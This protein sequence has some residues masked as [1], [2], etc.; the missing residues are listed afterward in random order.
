MTLSL[1]WMFYTAKKEKSFFV[2]NCF[3]SGSF[4]LC[5]HA[6]HSLGYIAG[7]QLFEQH[8][9]RHISCSFPFS[10]PCTVVCFTVNLFFSVSED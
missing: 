3:L 8:P 4:S 1:S 5:Y 7:D 6:A 10:C 2:Q 9:H